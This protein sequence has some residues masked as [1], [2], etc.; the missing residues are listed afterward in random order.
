MKTTLLKQRLLLVILIVS[1]TV[2]N[3]QILGERYKLGQLY[4]KITSQNPKEVSVTPQKENTPYWNYADKPSGDISIPNKVNIRGEYYKVTKIEEYALF[5]CPKVTSVTIPN[6]II[7]IS[8]SS[9]E[10]CHSLTFFNVD[11]ENT[12]YL[13]EDGVLFNKNKTILIKY[14]RG[15]KG[16]Q[17]TVSENV[18]IIGKSAFRNSKLKHISL[19]NSVVK[20]EE[21][22]FKNCNYLLSVNIPNG[23][24]EI[25]SNTFSNCKSLISIDIPN[26]VTAIGE[27]VF[28]SC[29]SITSITLPENITKIDN[30][31][32]RECSAL[33]SINLPNSIKEIGTKTFIYCSSI[34]SIISEIEDIS[35]VKMGIKVFE[36]INKDNCILTVPKGKLQ[37][38]KVADQ[39]ADFKNIRN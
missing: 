5:N 39:W 4:Y 37:E 7:N 16:T 22:A 11:I 20:I 9:F 28:Y 34:N 29:S 35:N 33:K 38:Y 8:S 26:S 6:S 18:K 21:Y 12:H 36:F 14:P 32:F 19:P 17:Y 31:A 30:Y 1:T 15:K 2:S 10:D 13:S 3:A 27:Y 23:I 24:K 25:K